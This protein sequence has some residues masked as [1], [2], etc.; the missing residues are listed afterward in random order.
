MKATVSNDAKD[1][2]MMYYTILEDV[3]NE[4]FA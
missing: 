3:L 4:L 2:E 1:A